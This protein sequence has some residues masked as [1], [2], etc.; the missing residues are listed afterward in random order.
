MFWCVYVRGLPPEPPG[1]GHRKKNVINMTKLHGTSIHSSVHIMAITMIAED[2]KILTHTDTH[3]HKVL[4][5]YR[6]G[7]FLLVRILFIAFLPLNPVTG[8]VF[9]QELFLQFVHRFFDW[10]GLTV[11]LA[12]LGDWLHWGDHSVGHVVHVSCQLAQ[13]E[14]QVAGQVHI[15]QAPQGRGNPLQC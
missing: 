10:H 5:Y 11:Q 1:H 4:G 7:M 6:I 3:A 9:S 8:H 14:C 2:Q 13:R 15:F 12:Y